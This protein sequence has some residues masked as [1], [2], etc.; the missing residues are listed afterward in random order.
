MKGRTVVPL[1]SAMAANIAITVNGFFIC[2]IFSIKFSSFY[3]LTPNS[4]AAGRNT[5]TSASTLNV[6]KK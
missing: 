6:D 4:V 1:I 3:P 5:M 2:P